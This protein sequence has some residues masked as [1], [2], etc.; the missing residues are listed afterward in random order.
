MEECM[1]IEMQDLG[2]GIGEIS[3]LLLDPHPELPSWQ[4]ACTDAFKK[5]ELSLLGG[6]LPQSWRKSLGAGWAIAPHECEC[7]CKYA[8]FKRESTGGNR[9]FGCV[10]HSTPQI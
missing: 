2:V 5:I 9:F 7:G 4:R 6:S 10:C 1:E 3:A 8:W